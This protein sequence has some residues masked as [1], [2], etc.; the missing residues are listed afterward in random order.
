MVFI[1]A[2]SATSSN[3]YAG[4][5]GGGGVQTATLPIIFSTFLIAEYFYLSNFNNPVARS[6]AFPFLLGKTWLNAAPNSVWAA[7]VYTQ[8]ARI[9]IA[10][11]YMWQ[12]YRYLRLN[13]QMMSSASVH[14]HPNAVQN[15]AAVTAI[16][17]IGNTVAQLQK[18][19]NNYLQLQQLFAMLTV[20]A[21][22]NPYMANFIFQRNKPAI[23]YTYAPVV[24]TIATITFIVLQG[25]LN[26]Y[27][28]ALSS[29]QDSATRI[30]HS[31]IL[32]LALIQYMIIQRFFYQTYF[33]AIS[34]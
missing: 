5:G 3:V 31:Q 29:R 7:T 14:N 25:L 23:D 27:T 10:M 22:Y 19:A 18:D 28:N 30:K 16:E 32:V 13:K 20:F 11:V 4:G 12:I 2:L 24:S 1:V 6:I 34:R 15:L 33:G 26:D 21:F 17:T 9:F 8:Q